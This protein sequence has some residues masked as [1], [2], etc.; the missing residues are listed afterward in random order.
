M[1]KA[2]I[3][4]VIALAVLVCASPAAAL[5]TQGVYE[6]CLPAQPACRAHLNDI[7]EAGFHL[8]LNYRAWE[9]RP[10]QLRAYARKA[11]SLGLELILPLNHPVWRAHGSA[12][13]AYPALAQACRCRRSARL[14]RY[15]LHL[16]DGLPAVWGWYIGDQ[17]LASEAPRVQGLVKV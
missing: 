10:A 9:A 17:L 11:Q 1:T 4:H 3:A 2:V 16:G 5:P 15:A 13:K 8:V 12:V 14:L 7:A 6:Q